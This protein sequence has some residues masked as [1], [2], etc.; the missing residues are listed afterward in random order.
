MVEYF[1]G[2]HLLIRYSDK[3]GYIES[4]IESHNNISTK[5]GNVWFGKLG[6]TLAY[7][8]IEKINNQILDK[9]P[10]AL[11]LIQKQSGVHKLYI[12]KINKIQKLAPPQSE[13]NKIPRYYET[14]NLLAHI[15]LWVNT[16][17]MHEVPMEILREFKVASSGSLAA[18]SLHKS[19]APMFALKT[20][21][22]QNL[23][24]ILKQFKIYFE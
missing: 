6:K 13:M 20:S 14:N 22:M 18:E 9:V 4:T 12:G 7:D 19:M 10:S 2:T 11:F 23:D 8:R 3:I 17:T 16:S 5:H 24:I 21:Y 1:G 15:K